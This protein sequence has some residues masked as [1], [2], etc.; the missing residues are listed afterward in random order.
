MVNATYLGNTLILQIHKHRTPRSSRENNFIGIIPRS[1]R[2]FDADTH[3]FGEK[4][5]FER[6]RTIG[7]ELDALRTKVLADG[8]NGLC[9]CKPATIFA[10]DGFPAFDLVPRE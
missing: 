5:C 6:A 1:I 2:N 7:A 9:S 4:W 3:T 10:E 8:V